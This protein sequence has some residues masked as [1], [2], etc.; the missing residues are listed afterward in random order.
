MVWFRNLL[1]ST[2]GIM[3]HCFKP[4][5]D[6]PINIRSALFH[7]EETWVDDEALQAIMIHF[8]NLYGDNGR[9]YLS[10]YIG[11]HSG[12]RLSGQARL[13]ALDSIGTGKK[14]AS[15]VDK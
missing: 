12:G 13:H 5:F 11:C 9:Y 4:A 7:A 2:P 8:D 6:F 14:I 1:T 15:A 10:L 3:D